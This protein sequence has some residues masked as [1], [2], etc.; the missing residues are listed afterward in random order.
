MKVHLQVGGFD[1]TDPL[2]DDAWSALQER[3]TPVI[4]HAGAVADGSGN[5]LWCGRAPVSRLLG[6]F[7]ELRLVIAHL[8]APDYDAFV[9]LAEQHPGVWL[10]TAMVF[11]DP[12]LQRQGCRTRLGAREDPS[13]RI[14]DG[15]RRDEPSRVH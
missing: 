3:G 8:G 9:A 11:T 12:P 5:E 4:L 10:D 15:C 6:R 14:P 2:L 7:P 1:A 13:S